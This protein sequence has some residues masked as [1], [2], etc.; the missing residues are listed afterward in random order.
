MS[1][2]TKYVREAEFHDKV[3]AE[4]G[5]EA[6]R[7]YKIA[8]SSKAFYRNYLTGHCGNKRVLEFGCGPDSHSMFLVPRGARVLGVDISHVAIQKYREVVRSHDLSNVDGCVMNGENLAFAARSFDLICGLGIL[9]HLDVDVSL[10]ELSRILK[11]DGSAV[12]LEPL[13]HN[14]VINVYR[15]MTPGMRTPDEHPLK[16]ADLR[17]A[18]KYFGRVETTYFHLAS[19]MAIPFNNS[20][21]FPSVLRWLESVDEL[22]FK[23]LRPLRRYAWAAGIV[24]S[25]PRPAA[26]R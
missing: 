8:R 2:E 7:F 16:M 1:P 5:R 11:P 17:T 22:I 24:C 14:P 18:R 9:H 23:Y 3:F 26:T 25:E 10:S 4:G 15:R 12:F 6:D 21:S 20:A 19:L 13:G